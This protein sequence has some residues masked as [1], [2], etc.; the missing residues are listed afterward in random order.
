[1][2]YCDNFC[3]RALSS[4]SHAVCKQCVFNV[5]G[6]SEGADEPG[7]SFKCPICRQGYDAELDTVKDLMA[8]YAPSHSKDM[9]CCCD[10][11][12]GK[13]FA[14]TH[15]ACR[16][17]CYRCDESRLDLAL[18]AVHGHSLDSESESTEMEIHSETILEE[19]DDEDGAETETDNQSAPANEWQEARQG[20]KPELRLKGFILFPAT[21]PCDIQKTNERVDALPEPEEEEFRCASALWDTRICSHQRPILRRW[22]DYFHEAKGCSEAKSMCIVVANAASLV[23]LFRSGQF[24]STDPVASGLEATGGEVPPLESLRPSGDAG[25]SDRGTPSGYVRLHDMD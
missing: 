17:G 22:G 3:K 18:I 12:C 1:M 13:T 21:G 8:C 20:E 6:T 7:F 14:V 5:M 10:N 25:A 16:E 19:E 2:P 15:H 11:D 23:R 4:C 24:P 9:P